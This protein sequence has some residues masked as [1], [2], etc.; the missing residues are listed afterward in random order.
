MARQQGRGRRAVAAAAGAFVRTGARRKAAGALDWAAPKAPQHALTLLRDALSAVAHWLATP[1]VPA[2]TASE[3]SAPMPVGQQGR[4]QDVVTAPEGTPPV[5]HGVAAERRLSI[6]D[7]AMRQGRNSRRLRVEGSKRQGRRALDSRW[8]VAVG[9]TPAT[10]P[11]ASGT[12]ASATDW[13]A[14]HCTRRAWP[15]DRA[16]LASQ[17]VQQRTATLAIFC[18]AWPV[19]QGPSWPKSA[20]QLDG[21]RYALRCP[22]GVTLPC[23]PGGVVQFPAATCQPGALRERCPAS[24]SGRS[25]R[26]PP[27][28]AWWQELRER[29]QTPPGRAQ[30]RERVA[31]EP[32]WAHVGRWQGRRARSRGV[33]KNVFDLRRC[34]VVQNL[35]VLRH[36]PQT[37][38]IA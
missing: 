27:D 29:Q 12:D 35:H 22:S 21:E 1:P 3:V 31:V 2:E 7:A 17:L 4:A 24:T 36:L 5:R 37:E 18:T 11:A 25:I 32:A 30:L 28:E 16:S 23:D 34:A 9:G 6:A 14:Q 8:M 38:Q 26:M 10:A 15:S 19:R 20:G 13:A 33:R